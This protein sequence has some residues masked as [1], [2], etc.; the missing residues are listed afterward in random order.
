[1]QKALCAFSFL[2]TSSCKGQF[3]ANIPIGG[4]TCH[5]SYTTIRADE[6]KKEDASR[7]KFERKKNEGL[8]NRSAA[9]IVSDI[10]CRERLKRPM[11]D[12]Q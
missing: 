6:G 7:S 9:G 4:D 10:K 11:I 3:N 2:R 12:I 1:M 8:A 5:S